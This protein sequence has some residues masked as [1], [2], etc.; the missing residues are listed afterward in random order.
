MTQTINRTPRSADTR[1]AG[2][3]K[4]GWTPPSR[5]DAPEAPLGYRLKW[6]RAEMAGQQDRANVAGKL[7]EGY[8]LVRAEEFPD[9]VVPS[10][11]D[12]RHAGVIGVGGLL[13]AK[14]TEEFAQERNAHYQGITRDQLRAVDNDMMKVN[15]HDTMVIQAPERR[16]RTTFGGPKPGTAE[17]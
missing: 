6:I 10:V 9:F 17:A 12:G 4:R 15:A 8:D 3:R 5:L 14:I 11:D 16:S 2:E 1:V 13:L 7:R